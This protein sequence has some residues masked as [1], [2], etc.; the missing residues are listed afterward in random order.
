MVNLILEFHLSLSVEAA[1]N[2]MDSSN[3]GRSEYMNGI[4]P[5]PPSREK[6]AHLIPYLI[7]P[8]KDPMTEQKNLMQMEN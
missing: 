6:P 4:S 5:A 2:G 1:V 3:I 8:P 7:P